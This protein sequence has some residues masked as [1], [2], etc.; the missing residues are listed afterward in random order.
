[1][2]PARAIL[3][4]HAYFV[5]NNVNYLSMPRQSNISE[6]EQ[7]AASQWGMF[8]TAQAQAL[9]FRRNQVSRMAS[10]MRVEPMCYGVYRFIAGSEPANADLKAAWLSAFPKETAA[11][12]LAKR[13][14]DAVV[15][16]GTAAA[17]LGAGDFHMSPYTFITAVRKQT[18]REDMRFLG[19][20]LDE[21][22]VVMVDGLPTTSFERTVFDLLRLDEDP[23]L[24]DGFMRDAA[25]SRGHAFDFE[26]LSELLGPIA[27]RHGFPE[28][29]AAFAADLVLRNASDV[30]VDR[31]NDALRSAVADICGS[32]AFQSAAKSANGLL[33][34]ILR[35]T[36]ITSKLE[37]MQRTLFDSIGSMH[38]E[39]IKEIGFP[40]T[41]AFA[42]EL[43]AATDAL[44]K[45]SAE[46]IASALAK[47]TRALDAP[48]E[49]N[50][51]VNAA[52]KE[53]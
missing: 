29:G 37:E 14:F 18:A 28:G 46:G 31:A 51:A 3:L 38:L 50:R 39:A 13:P 30:L 11:E 44:P 16:A 7:L 22:D 17:A 2:I 33:L 41:E 9:G 21:A 1:M 42:K 47:A 19:C 48:R 53:K 23:S 52:S 12:R 10:S 26:R 36:G 49:S 32:E 5:Y 20:S 15:A 45:P 25:R 6:L 24:V 4:Y 27:L 8:T 34:D 35:S 43:A 40:G